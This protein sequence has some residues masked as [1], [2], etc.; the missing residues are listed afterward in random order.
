MADFRIYEIASRYTLVK[1]QYFGDIN[2]YMKYSLLRIL[3]SGG[4]RKIAVCWMLTSNDNRGD[5]DK[6]T[7][8]HRPELW[9]HFD[10]ELFDSLEQCL[11][12]S[13]NR[14]IHWAETKNLIP[15]ATF[16]AKLLTDNRTEREAYF[17]EFFSLAQDSS[18]DLVFFDPDNGLEVKSKPLGKDGRKGSS[19]YLYEHEVRSTFDVGHSVLVYQHF[20]FITRERFIETQVQRLSKW[21]GAREIIS[22]RTQHVVFLLV[23]QSRHLQYFREQASDVEEI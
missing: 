3:A 9:R 23:P 6:T 18:C 14:D 2:D 8:V 4:K 13:R 16:Y 22:F 11:T 15:S 19:K 1:N 20:P 21:A 7:Y 12:N 5:G 17:Q 10:P